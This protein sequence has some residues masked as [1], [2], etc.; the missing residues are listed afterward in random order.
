[1]ARSRQRCPDCNAFALAC[2]RSTAVSMGDHELESARQSV[3]Q[4]AECHARFVLD[5]P[6]GKLRRLKRGVVTSDM[7][8][9]VLRYLGL[10]A[11]YGDKV[12]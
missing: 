8:R 1:M 11:L 2:T 7:C 6:A 5:I 4:C 10:D 3:W 9:R 12:P